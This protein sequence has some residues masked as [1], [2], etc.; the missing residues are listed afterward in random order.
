MRLR[1]ATSTPANASA[2]SAPPELSV[3][4]PGESHP[5]EGFLGGGSATA[6]ALEAGAGFSS[7]PSFCA[8]SLLKQRSF[9]EHVVDE[10]HALPAPQRCTALRRCSPACPASAKVPTSTQRGTVRHTSGAQF[11]SW[12]HT[13]GSHHANAPLTFPVEPGGQSVGASTPAC[14]VDTNN[15]SVARTAADAS[16]TSRA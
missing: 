10:G 8:W 9:T 14:A 12:M 11:P 16:F 1:R 6:G 3:R 13:E 7:R 4:V 15:V 5:H 2:T